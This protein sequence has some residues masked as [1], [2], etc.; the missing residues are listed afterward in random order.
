[1]PAFENEMRQASDGASSTSKSSN[2]R[3]YAHTHSTQRQSSV[4][5]LP[6]SPA[7]PVGPL[8]PR[9]SASNVSVNSSTNGTVSNAESNT[10]TFLDFQN[11]FLTCTTDPLTSQGLVTTSSPL[12]LFLSGSSA[13]KDGSTTH[14]RN[15]SVK[16]DTPDHLDNEEQS[17]SYGTLVMSRGGRSKYLGP[18]AGSEWL[19]DSQMQDVSCT[20]SATRCPSPEVTAPLPVAPPPLHASP[21][22]FPL[23]A[24]AAHIRTRDLL[25]QLPPADEAWSLIESYYR[26]CAWH[27]D[28]APK[29]RMEETFAR[30]YSF[31]NGGVS[32]SQPVNFQ[33]VALVFMIMSKGTAYNIEL[34]NDDPSA[35]EWQHLS[36]MALVKG[37]FLSNNT[38]AGVQ[39]LHIMA[40]KNFQ[41]DKG[42]HD[43]KAWLLWGLA[44]RMIQAM[45]L[46]RD[47]ARWNL[48][49]DIVQE[50]RKVFWEVNAADIFQ[51]HC[52]SRPCVINPD[53]YDTAFPTETA[54]VPGEKGY[55]QLRFEL[56]QLSGE[57]LNMAMKARRPLYS[58]VTAL[59]QKLRKFEQ[60]LPYYI[61]CRAALV[62]MLSRYPK[63]E[64]AIAAAPEAS[65][66]AMTISM[67]QTNL[68]INISETVINLHRPYYAKALY[69]DIEGGD[70][71]LYAPSFYAV[72]ERAAM[73][74][75]VVAD[76]H[77]RFPAI[78]TRQ[79]NFWYHV[80]GSALCLGTLVLRHPGHAMAN[81]VLL[82]IDTAIFL[83]TSLVQNGANTARY[84]RNLQWLQKLRTRAASKMAEASAQTM[85]QQSTTDIA[86]EHGNTSTD[87]TNPVMTT[88]DQINQ[89]TE[90]GEDV[91]L[92]GWRTRLIRHADQQHRQTTGNNNKTPGTA[93]TDTTPTAI[94]SDG[95]I[96]A[97][98]AILQ[99]TD[100][101]LREFWDPIILH[102]LLEVTN[103]QPNSFMN[104]GPS[105]WE[106]GPIAPDLN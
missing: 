105:W 7:R 44:M 66:L 5:D 82:Q 43:D 94:A 79:W 14:A 57:I 53:H 27:H 31:V 40:H 15:S 36:E 51:A 45:G 83:F 54:P 38:I 2:T 19:K 59:D 103:E 12:R 92:I 35:E 58:E 102:D 80:F 64:D 76:I 6:K 95:L 85:K 106:D 55:Y 81:F 77:A 3:P 52:F 39:T 34:P 4:S 21:I 56:S 33:E 84:Q 101:V 13:I 67:Q 98:Q 69:D 89:N 68:A 26:Y 61:R 46:H 8:G 47:G 18:T 10:P 87:T 74:I 32:S 70:K 48:P 49:E 90:D 50:R 1:M 93:T 100:D 60:G 37:D 97:S 91:E 88:P 30:V 42:R 65:R 78:S 104:N 99:S 73:I 16:R 41:S 28:V 9:G 75:A 23:N 86:N 96:V 22:A 17:G 24:S 62:A 29:A 63:A 25:A 71:S 11:A 72:I 20:P